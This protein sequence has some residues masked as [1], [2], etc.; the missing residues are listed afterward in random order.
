MIIENNLSQGYF[1]IV[2][3]LND[4]MLPCPLKSILNADCP[5]CGFQRSLISLLQ[6][7]ISTSF[8]LY[9]AAIPIL[10]LFLFGVIHL[11]F[12]LK[13]GNVII[14]YSYIFISIIIAINFLF[15]SIII[16]GQ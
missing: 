8:S 13:K 10:L 1:T 2:H 12:N 7:D 11:K 5:G 14:Q 4:H 15:K 16:N 9:P 6:G 3:W